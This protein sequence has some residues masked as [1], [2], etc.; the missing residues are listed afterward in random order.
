MLA[1]RLAADRVDAGEYSVLY[2]LLGHLHETIRRPI[3]EEFSRLMHAE[4]A[5]AQRNEI[6]GDLLNTLLHLTANTTRL[7]D[8]V[9]FAG[10]VFL[11]RT[12]LTLWYVCKP[13]DVHTL[14]HIPR[15]SR[16]GK[17]NTIVATL[18]HRH[19]QLR[20]GSCL[21]LEIIA[22][23]SEKHR[24]LS[25]GILQP[26]CNMK[27]LWGDADLTRLVCTFIPNIIE[28]VKKREE[29]ELLFR[30]FG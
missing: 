17:T 24:L 20:R 22:Q 29:L 3:I 10:D 6:S 13:S 30:L 2:E 5:D 11:P 14:T 18:E 21:A 4:D 1:H 15:S 9:S 28:F 23:S 26:C 12:A 27:R 25:A 16:L 8:V 19:P 7:P